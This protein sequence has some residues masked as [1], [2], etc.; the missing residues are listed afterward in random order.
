MTQMSVDGIW[1]LKWQGGSLLLSDGRNVDGM[2]GAEAKTLHHKVQRKAYAESHVQGIIKH[3][4]RRSASPWLLH[5]L[6]E[7]LE[8]AVFCSLHQAN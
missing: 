4:G 2:V 5:C 7:P 8:C 3:Q 6:H 1:Q